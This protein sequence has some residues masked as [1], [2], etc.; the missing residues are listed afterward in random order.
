MMIPDRCIGV[1]RD[2][3]L[4]CAGVLALNNLLIAVVMVLKEKTGAM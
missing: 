3:G 2:K 1:S 4:L